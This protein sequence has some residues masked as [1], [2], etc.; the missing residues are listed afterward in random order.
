MIPLTVPVVDDWRP[1]PAPRRR[2]RTPVQHIA[3]VRMLVAPHGRWRVERAEAGESLPAQDPADG[4]WGDADGS[5]DLHAGPALAA[6]C[7][8]TGSRPTA[9]RQ[10]E[11]APCTL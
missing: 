8:A 4:G 6:P 10:I 5:G 9:E 1:R 3:G 7:T 2:R 11:D